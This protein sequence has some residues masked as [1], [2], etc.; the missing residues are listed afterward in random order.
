MEKHTV[1]I[2]DDATNTTKKLKPKTLTLLMQLNVT[3]SYEEAYEIVNDLP[4]AVQRAIENLYLYTAHNNLYDTFGISAS[5]LAVYG[6]EPSIYDILLINFTK[7]GLSSVA[8]EVLSAYV[9]GHYEVRDTV[10][11][12]GGSSQNITNNTTNKK[13]CT[14]C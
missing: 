4:V 3:R 2:L 8:K 5:D 10:Q 7:D 13:I 14:I 11:R 6:D 12:G 1:Q 9:Q